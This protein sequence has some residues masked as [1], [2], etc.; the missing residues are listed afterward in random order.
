[1]VSE[2]FMFCPVD[3][4]VLQVFTQIVKIIAVPGHTYNQVAVFLRMFLGIAKCV[5]INYVELNMMA[6]HPE[7][8]AHQA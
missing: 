4:L 2:I 3:N 1:M 8:A 6:V 5:S 7:I